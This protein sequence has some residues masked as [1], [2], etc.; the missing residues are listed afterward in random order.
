MSVQ[1]SVPRSRQALGLS[2]LGVA[3]QDCRVQEHARRETLLRHCHS[4]GMV[5]LQHRARAGP[6]AT[7][8]SQPAPTG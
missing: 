8:A 4:L 3:K 6:H 7:L 1:S 5:C 2:E